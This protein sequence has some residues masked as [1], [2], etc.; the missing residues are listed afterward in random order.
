MIL[1]SSIPAPCPSH[2]VPSTELAASFVDHQV[3]TRREP[4]VRRPT[5]QQGLALEILGHSI[6]YLIDSNFYHQRATLPA[7]KEAIAILKQSNREV[8]ARAPEVIPARSRAA[9]WI[10]SRLHPQSSVAAVAPAAPARL[11]LVKR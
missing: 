4:I 7:V 6:E 1:A 8:F 9:R 10:R 2:V 11:L 5:P 3:P